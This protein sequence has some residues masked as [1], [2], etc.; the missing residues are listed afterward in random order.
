MKVKKLAPHIVDIMD[1]IHI[2]KY[3]DFINIG[4]PN[5]SETPKKENDRIT[6]VSFQ[7]PV[8]PKY[9]ARHKQRVAAKKQI[10]IRRGTIQLVRNGSWMLAGVR[11]RIL[12]LCLK[13]SSDMAMAPYPRA[14][15]AAMA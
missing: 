11:L 9:R 3:S 5:T 15:M 12:V 4:I 7:L 1:A 13:P 10:F 14:K 8:T 2:G 6:W